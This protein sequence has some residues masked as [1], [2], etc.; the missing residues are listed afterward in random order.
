[1]EQINLKIISNKEITTNIYEMKLEC[2]VDVKPGQF[3]NIKVDNCY[4]RRPIS[5]C[6]YEDDILTIVYKIV[7][8]GTLL[9]SKMNDYLD[10]L[11]GLGNG[12]DLDNSGDNPLLIGGGIGIVPL[13]YLAKRLI[14]KGVNVRA[15]LGFNRIEEMFYVDKFEDIGVQVFITTID[16]SF[17][18][19]GNVVDK[20]KEVDSYSYVYVCGPEIML[21]SVF[22]NSSKHGEYSFE[23]RMGCGFGVCMGCSCKTKYGSKRICVDGPVLKDS[24]I[25]W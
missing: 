11:I 20:L 2:H 10:A 21:K 3:I 4:L 5:V 7:G 9:L 23:E 14:E 13:Y 17:G 19:K 8:K 18:L 1:M 6:N 16:G 22:E 12:Y 24:E 25:I 15:I